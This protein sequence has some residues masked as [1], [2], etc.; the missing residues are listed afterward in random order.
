MRRAVLALGGNLGD[1][2]EALRR[3][4]D[5]LDALV[6][7]RVEAVSNVY[8]TDPVGYTDQPPFLNAAL[9]VETGLSPHALLGACLGIEAALG[10]VRTIKNGPRTVDIDLLMM[11]GVT[12]GEAELTLPHPRMRQRAFVLIPMRDLFADLCVFGQ[13]LSDALAQCGTQGVCRYGEKL[14]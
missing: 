11:E 7:T 10:R 1:R 2:M 13:D 4:A 3:A 5:A 6:D 14:R 12:C 9:L 8:E